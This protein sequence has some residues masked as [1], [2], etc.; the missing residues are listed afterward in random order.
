MPPPKANLT[1]FKEELCVSVG[2]FVEAVNLKYTMVVNNN[3]D[4]IALFFLSSSSFS[5]EQHILKMI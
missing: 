2:L 3:N 5:V 4:S 1:H